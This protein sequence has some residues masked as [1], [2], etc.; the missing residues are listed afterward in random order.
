MTAITPP[1][2]IA[3]AYATH[4][5]EFATD[6]VAPAASG[7]MCTLWLPLWFTASWAV[8]FALFLA[9]NRRMFRRWFIVGASQSQI[10]IATHNGLLA[11]IYTILPWALVFSGSSSAAV[12]GMV[13]VYAGALH[14]VQDFGLGRLPGVAST[15]PY[16]FP[17]V[18]PLA[19]SVLAEASIERIVALMSC[20]S[21]F[22]YIAAVAVQQVR[23]RAD[24]EEA[25]E[26]AKAQQKVAESEK[27]FAEQ[28]LET[29]L[30]SIAV[31]DRDLRFMAISPR[32]AERLQID[33]ATAIG[34]TMGEAIA[35]APAYWSQAQESALHGERIRYDAVPYPRPDGT[36]GWA[37]WECLPWRDEAGQIG[38]VITYGLDVSSI[39]EAR[40]T[41]EKSAELLRLALQGGKSAVY[42]VDLVNQ[43]ISFD[44]HSERVW[45]RPIRFEDLDI[46]SND[47]FFEEDKPAL[48]SL[49]R[50]AIKGEITMAEH[51]IRRHGDDATMFVGSAYSVQKNDS[52]GTERIVVMVT[53]VT[54][55]RQREIELATYLSDAERLLDSRRALLADVARELEL[56]AP[57]QTEKAREMVRGDSFAAD[58]ERFAAMAAQ[59][60]RLLTEIGARDAAL[61]EMIS[62][63]TDARHQAEASNAAKS[64]FLANMSHELR[65]PLNAIIGYSEILMEGAE[66]DDRPED[67]S[68]LLRVLAAAKRLLAL[69][70]EIL[71]LSKI[72]AGRME[73]ETA[74]FDLA[75]MVQAAIDTVRPAA[76]SNGNALRFTVAAD[77]GDAQGDSFRLSQCVLNL[78]SN[79]A[80]FTN[81][82]VITV[83]ARREF[84][85]DGD[86][87]VIAVADTGIG[88]P[89]EA[90]ARIFSPFT[91]A[92]ATTT[93][94]FGGT[95][96]GLTITKRIIDL[97]GGEIT[98]ESA[99]GKGS[100]FTLRV[101]SQ[102]CLASAAAVPS[103]ALTPAST[104]QGPAIL[105]VDPDPHASDLAARALGRLGFHIARASNAAEARALAESLSPALV[106]LDICLSEGQAAGEAL[107]QHLATQTSASVHT[108]VM[109]VS[110][111][112][113]L[114]RHV[115]LGACISLVKPVGRE[116]LCAAA[117][118]F[119]R[120]ADD[121]A[122]LAQTPQA[123]TAVQG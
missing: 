18:A 9:A 119:A 84:S 91:Q 110:A 103:L 120:R 72:E 31:L 68:D 12:V 36:T 61:R 13:M 96:L 10:K 41:A 15:A 50:H 2:A 75:A 24:L 54:A 48:K 89:D 53:D 121:T 76:A 85:A 73:L 114:Q 43:R 34:K 25:V 95:G 58:E 112:D 70:N 38:G 14:A 21:L 88:I 52:G 69:I 100:C 102:P 45:G 77:L 83:T 118:Q 78:L 57:T 108:P 106:V 51:R 109:I 5:K 105:I 28:I 82:G 17:A 71:D 44:L 60:S 55:R 30:I 39:M 29:P 101:P 99:P 27:R 67:V 107:L 35:W 49:F 59:L 64:A 66:D 1:H 87:F 80:K 16:L 42:E 8:A 98:L 40:H 113:D 123:K 3:M 7:L 97:M 93:R 63:L 79:A 74:S 20:T 11:L 46:D 111:A 65:T 115:A 90:Q 37:T 117:L 122:F 4:K 47:R 32:F 56:P 81:D 86:W 92:D 6:I 116:R 19:I 94:A 22:I 33:R 104:S 23:L 26:E 62:A